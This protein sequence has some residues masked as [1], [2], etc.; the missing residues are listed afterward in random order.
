[1]TIILYDI[2]CIK[3]I[4]GLY[5]YNFKYF[6]VILL[7]NLLFNTLSNTC[8]IRQLPVLFIWINHYY[9]KYTVN[10]RYIEFQGE[11][12]RVRDMEFI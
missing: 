10:S 4:L 1:M 6:Y 7:I 12:E 2:W 5:S 8:T 3:S 9:I 11:E